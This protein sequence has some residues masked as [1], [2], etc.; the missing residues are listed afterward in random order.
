MQVSKWGNSLAVRLPK[1]VVEMLE[2]KEGDDVR[3][4]VAGK[5]S[6]EIERDRS[7]EEAL[8]E[9]RAL[10]RPLPPGFKFDRNEANES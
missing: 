1:A 8:A 5:R 6:L 7:R 9:L 4:V 10:Q 2:L 3:V